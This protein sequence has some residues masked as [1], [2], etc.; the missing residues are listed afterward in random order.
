MGC[1]FTALVLRGRIAHVLHVGDTRAYRLSGDRL[2][3]LTTDH[4]RARRHRPLAHADPR[5]RRRGG[6]AA[7][8]RD[9]SR[10]RCTTASCLCSDGVHGVSGATRA[11]A[12]ILRERS[13]PEDTARALVAAA[14]DA[15]STDNCT[16]LVLDVVALPTARSADIGAAIMQLPL[17]PV[18]IDGETIDGFVL[19]VLMSDG[20]YSRLFGAVD[21]VEGGEVALKFPKPQVAASPPIAPPSSARPGSA[22]GCTVPGSGASSSCRRGGRPASTR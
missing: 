15:G 14:L 9:A 13:A 22:R 12:D 19:K 20:R 18:P 17:I 3:C 7:R 6:G 4:V 10:W 11:I 8:L 1:T 5:A 2:T 16:A 21:E